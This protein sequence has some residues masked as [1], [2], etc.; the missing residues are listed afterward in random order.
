MAHRFYAARWQD[1]PARRVGH[2]HLARIIRATA[3]DGH[4]DYRDLDARR[5]LRHPGTARTARAGERNGQGD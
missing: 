4:P 3:G 5:Q 2:A 1:Y